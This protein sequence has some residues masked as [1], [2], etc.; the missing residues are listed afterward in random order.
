MPSQKSKF[1]SYGLVR[2][3][4]HERGGVAGMVADE[5][6]VELEGGEWIVPKEAVPDYLPALIQ[7]TNTGRMRQA[8]QNGNS[9]MDAL[10][11]SASMQ[12][13]I[14]EPKSPMY[15]NGGEIPSF[16]NKKDFRGF[17]DKQYSLMNV[18]PDSYDSSDK[19]S[20]AMYANPEDSARAVFMDKVSDKFYTDNRK[21]LLDQTNFSSFLER[22]KNPFGRYSDKEPAI[23]KDAE[24]NYLKKEYGD[25]LDDFLN[26]YNKKDIKNLGGIIDE[27]EDGGRVSVK[28][29][30]IDAM[31][32][33][34][35]VSKGYSRAD[36]ETLDLDTLERLQG[37][38]LERNIGDQYG[39]IEDAL[40]SRPGSADMGERRTYANR[41]DVRQGFGPD[42]NTSTSREQLSVGSLPVLATLANLASRAG[43][44]GEGALGRVL[45]APLPI[46]RRTEDGRTSFGLSREQGGMIE[47]EDGGE[48]HSRRMYNQ[49]DK[50]KYGYEMGGMMPQYQE[51]GK[52]NKYFEKNTLPYDENVFSDKMAQAGASQNPAGF[53]GAALYGLGAG[54]ATMPMSDKQRSSGAALVLPALAALYGASKFRSDKAP[55]KRVMKGKQPLFR[56]IDFKKVDDDVFMS[57]KKGWRQ[58]SQNAI[59]S[60]K[61]NNPE[62][63]EFYNFKKGGSVD[64]YQDGGQVQGLQ[65]LV[66]SLGVVGSQGM[67]G[68]APPRRQQEIRN[69]DMFIGPPDSLVGRTYR[70]PFTGK[71][72][73]A[74]AE[75]R[76]IE[77]QTKRLLESMKK[78]NIPRSG[79]RMVMREGGPVPYQDGGQVNPNSLAGKTVKA[80]DLGLENLGEVTDMPSP[81]SMSRPEFEAFTNSPM[82]EEEAEEMRQEQLSNLMSIVGRDMRIRPVQ[83]DRY[84]IKN[85]KMSQTEMNIPKLSG[86]YLSSFGF[87]TPYSQRQQALLQRKMIAPETLNPKVKGLINRALVQRLANE[88]D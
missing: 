82:S 48:V 55:L 28:S 18:S 20:I 45:N 30:L 40:V 52:I 86:A 88:E 25:S 51:G 21:K 58:L 63:A 42:G 17:L 14:S 60:I 33:S 9:A 39:G 44:S 15:Q 84:I 53:P 66:D 46:E 49:K 32:E 65:G 22:S 64:Y 74:E 41:F 69:P 67:L 19:Y 87:E 57:S 37:T 35:G 5:Q 81:F 78:S 80:S 6:P 16:S 27:Y 26:I 70:N 29:K 75:D 24:L 10:I 76:R 12:N 83:P 85:G 56:E 59:D 72:E 7:M 2:G 11:A 31:S 1:P 54:L 34:N 73:D 38:M 50:K 62:L 23:R 68:N 77:Q 71:Y 3:P 61:E 8:M 47:Y 43:V 79:Q 36:L 4:S 13:G